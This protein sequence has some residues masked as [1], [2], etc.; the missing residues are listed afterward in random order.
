MLFLILCGLHLSTTGHFTH[1]FDNKSITSSNVKLKQCYNMN[2]YFLHHDE[3]I[4]Q[5]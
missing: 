2:K 5:L 3:V 4:N 1:T